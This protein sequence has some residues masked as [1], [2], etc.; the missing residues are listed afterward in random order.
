MKLLK[1]CDASLSA[2]LVILSDAIVSRAAETMLM[3][4][5]LDIRDHVAA[6]DAFASLHLDVAACLGSCVSCAMRVHP[7]TTDLDEQPID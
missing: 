5:H 6:A 1:G 7:I 3:R 4:N 2:E